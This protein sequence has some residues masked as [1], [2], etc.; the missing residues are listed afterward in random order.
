MESN[1]NKSAILNADDEIDF[2]E[3]FQL[4]WQKKWFVLSVTGCFH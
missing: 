3:L 1:L 2:K 4:I